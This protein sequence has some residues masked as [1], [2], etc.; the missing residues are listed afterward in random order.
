MPL[1]DAS[2]MSFNSV[3]S[4]NGGGTNKNSSKN[5][6]MSISDVNVEG[7]ASQM[8]SSLNPLTGPINKS[9]ATN[10]KSNKSHYGEF[11]NAACVML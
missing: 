11:S 4:H 3:N 1:T 7:S 5:N 2:P 9:S 10:D 8:Q 6:I